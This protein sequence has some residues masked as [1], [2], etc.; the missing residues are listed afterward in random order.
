MHK[1]LT[2][3][4]KLFVYPLHTPSNGYPIVHCTRRGEGGGRLIRAIGVTMHNACVVSVRFKNASPKLN[5]QPEAS[6]V[7]AKEKFFEESKVR[8]T[9]NAL[10]RAFRVIRRTYRPVDCPPLVRGLDQLALG[11]SGRPFRSPL[12]LFLCATGHRTI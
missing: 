9:Q 6:A 10:W 4:E 8:R 2:A 7:S 3:K 5:F 12:L 11:R 1:V